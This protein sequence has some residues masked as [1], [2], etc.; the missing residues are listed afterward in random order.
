MNRLNFNFKVVKFSVKD[1]WRKSNETI[2]TNSIE[3]KEES[4]VRF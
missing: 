4:K 2:S 3:S 1:G